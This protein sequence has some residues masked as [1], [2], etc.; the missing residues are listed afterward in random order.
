MAHTYP[1]HHLH[2]MAPALLHTYVKPPY[3]GINLFYTL[4]PQHTTIYRNNMATAISHTSIYRYH[5]ILH[6]KGTIYNP[7]LTTYE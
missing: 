6:I 5:L 1:Q 7:P 2:N 3:I 4:C